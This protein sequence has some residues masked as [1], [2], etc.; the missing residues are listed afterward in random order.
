ML[1]L[2]LLDTRKR[3]CSAG[4]QYVSQ[5]VIVLYFV[6]F[7]RINSERRGKARCGIFRI[8]LHLFFLNHEKGI[9]FVQQCFSF[10]FHFWTHTVNSG[11]YSE[12]MT[13]FRPE[14]LCETSLLAFGFFSFFFFFISFE[15]NEE[16]E[17]FQFHF[18]LN[19]MMIKC[20]SEWFECLIKTKT[21]KN[22]SK[23]F[24]N[25]ISF[26][27]IF[28]NNLSSVFGYFWSPK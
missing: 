3:L 13:K 24:E 26:N 8:I 28:T 18:S 27:S 5:S 2:L 10:S 17:K 4:A 15:T 23:C 12:Q 19:P 21:L 22:L 20:I 1:L 14:T 9:R 7:L 16:N 25:W 11:Y 6:S